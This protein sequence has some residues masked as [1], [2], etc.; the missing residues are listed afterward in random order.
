[1]QAAAPAF[2]SFGAREKPIGRTRAEGRD[3]RRGGL[4]VKRVLNTDPEDVGLK[5]AVLAFAASPEE[6]V[7]GH[8]TFMPHD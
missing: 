3:H 2:S 5:A 8:F 6:L 7:K 1:V 4:L